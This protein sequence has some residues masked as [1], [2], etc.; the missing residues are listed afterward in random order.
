MEIMQRLGQAL[1]AEKSF[2]GAAQRVCQIL[3]REV[4]HYT[5]VGVYVVRG[6]TLELE[7]WDGPAATQHVRIPIGQGICGLAA[8]TKETVLVDDVNK[9]PRYLM[10]FPQT[11]SEI[12]V[13]ILKN[14][15][16]LGEIDIDAEKAEAFNAMDRMFLEWLAGLLADKFK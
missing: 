9:D 4:P 15:R 13:P 5:W 1:V 3:R 11:R 8:R 12:V 14:G 7:A 2:K 10:C 6:E 16:C